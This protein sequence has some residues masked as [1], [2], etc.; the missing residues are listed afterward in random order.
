MGSLVPGVT[1]EQIQNHTKLCL[2]ALKP[3]FVYRLKSS[4]PSY[5]PHQNPPRQLDAYVAKVAE[6]LTDMTDM[7]I[8]MTWLSISSDVWN[9]SDSNGDKASYLYPP[10]IIN[11]A[12]K[13]INAPLYYD[14]RGNVTSEAPQAAMAFFCTY[15]KEMLLHG[16]PSSPSW[17]TPTIAPVHL[18]EHL[19]TMAMKV[20]DL[21]IGE[22][23][24]VWMR[25]KR[26]VWMLHEMDK[27]LPLQ[28]KER[29]RIR[30]QAEENKMAAS[31]QLSAWAFSL[32]ELA[33]GFELTH[34]LG[35]DGNDRL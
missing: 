27:A 21:S 16:K 6:R 13:S 32:L 5:Q 12:M 14:M 20:L 33:S 9:N 3:L 28:D 26:C 10:H 19:K 35:L 17:C 18:P 4:D 24:D 23:E 15:H 31:V 30:S 2:V 1:P 11:L 34:R 25:V 7:S 29:Q 8:R 22:L